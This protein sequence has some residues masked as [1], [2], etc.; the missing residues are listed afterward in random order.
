MDNNFRVQDNYP[1]K[2]STT[3]MENVPAKP[4]GEIVILLEALFMYTETLDKTIHLLEAKLSPILNPNTPA[5]PEDPNKRG[6]NSELGINL[7]KALDRISSI[8]RRIDIVT[9][10]LEI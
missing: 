8:Q 10:S 9:Q 6:A 5:D 7:A 3:A 1:S 2:H 4:I